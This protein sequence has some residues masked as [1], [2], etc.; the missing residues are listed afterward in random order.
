MDGDVERAVEYFC[1]S[2]KE[3]YRDIFIDLSDSLSSLAANMQKIELNYLRDGIAKYSILRKQ[4]IEG[5]EITVVYDIYFIKNVDGIWRI[6][7][8]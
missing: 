3:R 2:S 1:E 4:A 5:E 8:F 7:S 6:Q